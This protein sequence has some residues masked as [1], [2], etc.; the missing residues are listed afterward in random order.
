M[1]IGE[2][3]IVDCKSIPLGDMPQYFEH[4]R[5]PRSKWKVVAGYRQIFAWVL[6]DAR[7]FETPVRYKHPIGAVTWVRLGKI[8]DQPQNFAGP[9]QTLSTFG[10]HRKF[11]SE[12]GRWLRD[13][14]PQH[15]RHGIQCMTCGQR[16]KSQQGLSSHRKHKHPEVPAVHEMPHWAWHLLEGAQPH[17]D[18]AEP[19]VVGEAKEFAREN[20]MD[21]E[22]VVHHLVYCKK[23]GGCM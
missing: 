7:F 23:R 4:H 12:K 17:A 20:G 18:G 22:E 15:V 6:T 14:S 19:V 5:I 21:V 13:D 16:F 8:D 10:V 9:Q 11:R 3:R 1:L 2:A